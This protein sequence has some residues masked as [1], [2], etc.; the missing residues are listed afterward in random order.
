MLKCQSHISLDEMKEFTPLFFSLSLH[1]KV[2]IPFSGVLR[3]NVTLYCR[4]K[5]EY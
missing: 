2:P 1:E 4:L 5:N 3:L